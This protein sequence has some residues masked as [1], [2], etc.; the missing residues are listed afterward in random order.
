MIN[1]LTVKFGNKFTHKHVNLLY[2]S[3][4]KH[5]TG[6]FT[7]Y[8]LTDNANGLDPDIKFSIRE[9]EF[10]YAFNKVSLMKLSNLLSF[11]KNVSEAPP[12]I[13]ILIPISLICL[14][15]SEYAS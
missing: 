13:S 12:T 6:D 3:I 1:I 4:K 2:N 11:E 8:C 7:F 9:E 5:Y 14:I 10:C 15:K